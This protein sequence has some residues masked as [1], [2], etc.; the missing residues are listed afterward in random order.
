[1]NDCCQTT[2]THTHTH[3]HTQHIYIYIYIYD[4]IFIHIINLI[5]FLHPISILPINYTYILYILYVSYIC[6][7]YLLCRHLLSSLLHCA[8]S[9][10]FFKSLWIFIPI[11]HRIWQ[12]IWTGSSVCKEHF[13][14]LMNMSIPQTFYKESDVTPTN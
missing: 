4:I 14:G 2:H 7:I 11:V 8:K 9:M 6:I 13:A 5:S 1:M 10:E 3:T 12:I